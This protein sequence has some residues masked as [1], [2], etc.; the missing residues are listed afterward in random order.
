[1]RRSAVMAVLGLL[2]LGC[3]DDDEYGPH[4]SDSSVLPL[5]TLKAD[6]LSTSFSGRVYPQRHFEFDG[7]DGF[8][9]GKPNARLTVNASAVWQYAPIRVELHDSESAI[10][11]WDVPVVPPELGGSFQFVDSQPLTGRRPERA[12]VDFQ[13]FA[14]N[15]ILEILGHD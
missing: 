7:A 8:E 4:W 15:C 2:T 13:D 14:G 12:V 6:S 3:D 5:F 9:L 10:V 11:R 1:M